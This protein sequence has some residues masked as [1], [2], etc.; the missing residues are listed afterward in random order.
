M[1]KWLFVICLIHSFCLGAEESSK[2]PFLEK[3]KKTKK[4]S[5]SKYREEIAHTSADMLKELSAEVA[6]IGN[7]QKILIEMIEQVADGEK[8][9]FLFKISTKELESLYS[10]LSSALLETHERVGE[11]RRL[12]KKISDL[13]KKIVCS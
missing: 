8:S 4:M 3:P 1:H 2:N 13:N 7:Q 12:Q 5:E 10:D 11:L 6:L 9:S